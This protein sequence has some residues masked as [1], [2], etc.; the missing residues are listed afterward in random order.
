MNSEMNNLLYICILC[1]NP[2]VSITFQPIP[3]AMASVLALVSPILRGVGLRIFLY[4]MI[5]RV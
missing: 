1:H 3:L 4:K 5:A 2:L